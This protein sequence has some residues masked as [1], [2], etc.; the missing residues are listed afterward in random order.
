MQ[1]VFALHFFSPQPLMRAVSFDVGYRNLAYCVSDVSDGELLAI[2]HWEVLSV[3]TE[4]ARGLYGELGRALR[5]RIAHWDACAVALVEKQPARTKKKLLGVQ[6]FLEGF[7][8]ALGAEVH[9]VN[10]ALKVQSEAGSDSAAYRK[11]KRKAIDDVDVLLSAEQWSDWRRHFHCAAQKRDD[12]ADCLL[13]SV[14][15]GVA[16]PESNPKVKR[17]RPRAPTP[18]QRERRYS[19]ANLHWLWKHEDRTKLVAQKRFMKDL[20]YYYQSIDDLVKAF[21]RKDA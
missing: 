12:L 14:R 4:T 20:K 3:P 15:S 21:E 7:F 5:E 17:V 2:H 11:R 13:Q 10:P 16:S 19:E 18:A 1:H 9:E 8:T 6:T